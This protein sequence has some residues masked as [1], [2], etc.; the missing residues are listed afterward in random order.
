V[1]FYFF[2][3]LKF[4]PTSLLRGFNNNNN[5]NNNKTFVQHYRVLKY[6]GAGGSTGTGRLGGTKEVEFL[7]VA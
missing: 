1:S 7:N 4:F 6:R 2:N 5:N 3:F